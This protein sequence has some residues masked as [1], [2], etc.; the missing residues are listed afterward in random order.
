MKKTAVIILVSIMAFAGTVY[1]ENEKSDNKTM[2]QEE[3]TDKVVNDFFNNIEKTLEDSTKKV[4]DE[5]KSL[6]K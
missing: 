2:S 3:K 4:A 5:I 1:A 6:N